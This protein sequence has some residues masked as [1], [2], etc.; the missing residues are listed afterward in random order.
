MG[1][2]APLFWDPEILRTF[3]L[4]LPPPENDETSISVREVLRRHP[5]IAPFSVKLVIRLALVILVGCA[6]LGLLL[7][8]LVML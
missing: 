3:T 2:V 8:G 5:Y 6:G 4:L 1:V 7:A